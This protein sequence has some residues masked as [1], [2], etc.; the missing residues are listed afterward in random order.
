VSAA[1]PVRL[2]TR[3]SPLALAQ[4]ESVAA[5]LR[6]AWPGLAVELQTVLTRGDLNRQVPLAELAGQDGVFTRAVEA[7]VLAGRAD[8]AVHSLKDVPTQTDERLLLA[9]FPARADARDVLIAD[10][11]RGLA[12]LPAQAVVGTSS[13]RRAAQIRLARPDLRVVSVRGNVETR[14]SKLAAGELDGLLLAAAGLERLGRLELVSEYLDLE[15][16]TPAVGQGALAAQ[17][18]RDDEQTRRLLELLDS[19][20]TR[21]AVTAERAFL[22]AVGG[23]CRL[24]LGAYGALEGERLTLVGF[25]ASA[26]GSAAYRA[27]LSGQAAQPERL[28]LELAERLRASLAPGLLAEVGGD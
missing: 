21:A 6:Q 15:R 19:A 3:G 12:D 14:L 1:R 20:A 13:P 4:S 8:L 17:C 7:E 11:G 22:R 9:A 27:R 25:L 2:A 10:Q 16:F 23:G 5:A 26:D 24:P 28:G 18:R